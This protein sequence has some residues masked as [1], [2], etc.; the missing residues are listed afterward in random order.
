MRIEK[1]IVKKLINSGVKTREDLDA[2]KRK[3]AK[4]YRISCPS[5]IQLLKAYHGLVKQKSVKRN[6]KWE[7]LLRT[8]PIRSLS[9]IINVSVLTK[10]YPCPGKCIYCPQEKGVPKSYLSGEPAVQRAQKL[11]YHP[12]SQ[13]QERIKM[14]KKQGHPTDK[15]DLRI[16]GSTWSYYPKKYQSWFIKECFAAANKKRV[17]NLEE[18]KRLNEK[19]KNRIIGIS[20]ETRP[21]F[22][23]QE[24]IKRLR[25]L[26]VT[27]VELGVQSIHDQVL[28]KNLR[29]HKVKETIK[30]T[31]LLKDSGFKVSYQVMP[32]LPGSN[33]KKDRVMFKQL[34]SN[35]NFKPDLLKIYPCALLREAPL[36]RQYLKGRYRPYTK[37]TLINI[38]KEAKTK[39]PYYVRIERI[40]RDISA[41]RIVT[42]P[43]KISNLR[44]VVRA[45]MQKE[46]LKCK[47]VRCREIKEKYKP[48]E[49]FCLF[50]QSY[51]A[52]EGK[53][54]FFSFEN[55]KRTKLYSLLRLRIPSYVFV[56][57]R[58]KGFLPVLQGA[59]IIREVHTYGQQ[60]PLFKKTIAPQHKGLGKRLIKEAEKISCQEFGLRK[61]V[62]ISGVGVRNY[63]R[64]LGYQLKNEYMVKELL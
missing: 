14:L 2:F 5:N 26:G 25:R 46:S 62:A 6:K 61:I 22:I 27:K 8:R 9:G 36:Y 54:F 63:W 51:S 53:E 3:V 4:E 44:E 47:C 41:P 42:G 52:S 37:K 45:E 32:N 29:G 60:V 10:P 18:A 33:P 55:K 28:K 56:K 21:D 59:A 7:E 50:S 35:P 15:I 38:I 34:F 30:A 16:I 19:A 31:R 48:G 58:K 17:K 1:I 39:I 43:A 49:K 64:K 57:N 24:E 11:K 20:V 23:T 13:I 40:T 12:F